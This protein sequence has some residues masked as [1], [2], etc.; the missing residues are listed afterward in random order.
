MA[1]LLLIVLG[2]GPV[3]AQSGEP[4]PSDT[5]SN[6][7]RHAD[8]SFDRQAYLHAAKLYSRIIIKQPDNQQVLLRLA[9]CYRLMRDPHNAVH[10][11]SK[12]FAKAYPNRPEHLYNYA[13]VLSTSGKYQQA[14]TWYSRYLEVNPGDPRALAAIE[15]LKNPEQLWD[16]NVEVELIPIEFPGPV[17]SPA[18]YSGGLVFV[19]EGNTGGLARSVTTWTEAPYF[20]LYYVP[21]DEHGKPGF[22]KYL[23][24]KLNSVYHEGPVAFFDGGKK[25]MLTRSAARKGQDD[26]RNLQLMMAERKPSG[27]WSAP[28]KIFYERNYSTGHPA[29]N[30]EGTIIYFSSNRPGGYGG[31]DLYRSEYNNGKWSEPVNA[32]PQINTSGNELFPSLDMDGT[33]YFSSDGHGGLGGLDIFK[34]STRTYGDVVNLGYP[35]NSH[36]DDFGMAFKTDTNKGYFSSNRNGQDRIFRFRMKPQL[37]NSAVPVN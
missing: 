10:W 34:S 16:S 32:G 33:L 35:I 4:M 31:S 18:V 23:D 8:N 15:S 25:V 11:Y 7:R 2:V 19:G 1:M 29:I 24:D 6:I 9:D 20:D 27:R 13:S 30:P 14:V 21:V 5:G 28:R 37:A 12:A 26:T 17:F 3:E 36:R 22:P